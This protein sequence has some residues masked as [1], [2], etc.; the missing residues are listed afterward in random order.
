MTDPAVPTIRDSVYV[1]ETG[2]PTGLFLARL[3]QGIPSSQEPIP[4]VEMHNEAMRSNYRRLVEAC[5]K[6]I[7]PQLLPLIDSANIDMVVLNAVPITYPGVHSRQ[8][9]LTIVIGVESG[10]LEPEAA[11]E[12]LKRIVPVVYATEDFDDVAVE[13]IPMVGADEEA[14]S[15][16]LEFDGRLLVRRF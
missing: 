13:M 14:I 8:C 1:L 3:S 4:S 10:T 11:V 15:S 7:L 6:Q 5:D 9:L 2:T 12:F 16:L